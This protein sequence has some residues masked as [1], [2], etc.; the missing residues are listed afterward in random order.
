MSKLCFSVCFRYTC[1]IMISQVFCSYKFWYCADHSYE[2]RET[3]RKANAQKPMIIV[4]VIPVEFTLW[5]SKCKSYWYNLGA[6]FNYEILLSVVTGVVLLFAGN[7]VDKNC[8]HFLDATY[9]ELHWKCWKYTKIKYK[10]TPF[11]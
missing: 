8:F 1:L 7:N 5:N 9:I 2:W 3:K 10:V 6:H 11:D 4:L